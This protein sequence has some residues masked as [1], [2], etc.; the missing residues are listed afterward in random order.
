MLG[1]VAI[2]RVRVFLDDPASTTPYAHK[3]GE[4]WSEAQILFA[5]NQSQLAVVVWLARKRQTYLISGLLTSTT[6]T[7]V[8]TNFLVATSGECRET[9]PA[10]LRPAT[11][12]VG[13]SALDFYLNQHRFITAIYGETID[14]R[15][16]GS[17]AAAGKLWY[18]RKPTAITNASTNTEMDDRVYDKIIAHAVCALMCKDVL[19]KRF[20]DVFSECMRVLQSEV[21]HH[22]PQLDE[23]MKA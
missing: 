13:W 15:I 14:Y 11:L 7:T 9:S 18:I 17:A 21:P 2:D 1:S 8:P 16:N 12:M 10:V 19:D 22:Y 23:G 4:Y 20:Q 3:M 5:L 6:A